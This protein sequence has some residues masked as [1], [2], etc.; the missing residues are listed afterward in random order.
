[1]HLT[2]VAGTCQGGTCP[3]IYRTER[4]TFVVQGYTVTDTRDL[5]LQAHETAVEVPAALVEDLARALAR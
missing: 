5:A 2:K 3:T 1:M 4:G